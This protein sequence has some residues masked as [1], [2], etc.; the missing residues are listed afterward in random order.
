MSSLSGEIDFSRA[1]TILKDNLIAV[2]DSS[3]ANFITGFTNRANSNS[4]GGMSNIK[5]QHFHSHHI[6]TGE[7]MGMITFGCGANTLSMASFQSATL[8]CG[9]MSTL[10]FLF[11]KVRSF[12]ISN[13]FQM[14]FHVPGGRALEF[15]IHSIVGL[16]IFSENCS[17]KFEFI[18]RIY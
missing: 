12:P 17:F 5:F 1:V 2:F 15:G 6:I 14:T 18:H 4:S 13:E 7:I 16:D 8:L 11:A 10:L 3:N 9:G